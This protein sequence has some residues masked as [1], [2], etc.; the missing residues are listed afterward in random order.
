MDCSGVLFTPERT[1]YIW[2][3][4]HTAE[5]L[6]INRHF[7][8]A[9]STPLF[10]DLFTRSPPFLECL[11]KGTRN[12]FRY[13]NW[14]N[15]D[16]FCS[17]FRVGSDWYNSNFDVM[18]LCVLFNQIHSKG[19]SGTH[20]LKS[21]ENTKYSLTQ[22]EKMFF[23]LRI[24]HLSHPN[25]KFYGFHIIMYIFLP[26]ITLNPKSI[27]CIRYIKTFPQVVFI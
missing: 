20:H 17:Y 25:S 22:C 6:I 19:N 5:R 12:Y 4:L 26:Q 15:R 3:N 14:L 18:K 1:N 9:G 7:H 13:R 24:L 10:L 16:Y 11:H 23:I 2:D 27:F 21:S 8:N